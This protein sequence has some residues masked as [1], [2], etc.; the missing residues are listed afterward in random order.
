MGGFILVIL[1]MITKIN[2]GDDDKYHMYDTIPTYVIMILKLI[3]YMCFL[4]GIAR[5]LSKKNANLHISYFFKCLA[6]VGSFGFLSLFLVYVGAGTLPRCEREAW[7]L[8]NLEWSAA[9]LWGIVSWQLADRKSLYQRV[10][11]V[12]KSFMER[13]NKYF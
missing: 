1:T 3:C 10:S 6:A 11:L 9:L 5:S 7:T 13:D 12:G 2:D 8:V 4:A